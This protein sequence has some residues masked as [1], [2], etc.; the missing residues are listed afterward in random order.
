MNENQR[1]SWGIRIESGYKRMYVCMADVSRLW[2]IGSAGGRKS[3]RA[4]AISVSRTRAMA[5]FCS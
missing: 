2:D 3:I 5:L 1:S 4:R